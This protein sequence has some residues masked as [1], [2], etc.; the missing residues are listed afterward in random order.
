MTNFDFL[1]ATPDFD[2]FSD[3][4]I[5]AQAPSPSRQAV[6][7]PPEW[8]AMLGSPFGRAVSGAD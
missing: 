6:P 7:P 4:A 2:A 3:V 1:K 8:E 5:S